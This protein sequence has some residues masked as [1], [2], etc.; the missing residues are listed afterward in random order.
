MRGEG[1]LLLGFLV[2]KAFSCQLQMFAFL[3]VEKRPSGKMDVAESRLPADGLVV[4]AY[5]LDY[6][7]LFR[8]FWERADLRPNKANGCQGKK[9]P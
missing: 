7:D 6:G 4:V 3:T 2:P 9:F 5:L 8:I 1:Q